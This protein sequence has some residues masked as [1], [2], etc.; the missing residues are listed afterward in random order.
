MFQPQ[1][2]H[3]ITVVYLSIGCHIYP[4]EI[5]QSGDFTHDLLNICVL[6]DIPFNHHIINLSEYCK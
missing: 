4:A 2:L 5:L 1:L 3:Y 6:G